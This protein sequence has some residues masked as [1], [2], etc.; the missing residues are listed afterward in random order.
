M[1]TSSTARCSEGTYWQQAQQRGLKHDQVE[2]WK[3]VQMLG[4]LVLN[5]MSRVQNT[6]ECLR[7]T[8]QVN[9]CPCRVTR[10]RHGQLAG[11]PGILPTVLLTSSPQLIW[12]AGAQW[13]FLDLHPLETL[14]AGKLFSPREVSQH[15]STSYLQ[16]KPTQ[17]L[18]L[19]KQLPSIQNYKAEGVLFDSLVCLSRSVGSPRGKNRVEEVKAR[20]LATA[21]G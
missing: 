21:T 10:V 6:G 19:N 2:S 4:F 3:R 7:Q 18:S 13:S 5:P 14:Q 11:F 15:T 9:R 17:L 1:V 20:C 8:A 12:T 16:S